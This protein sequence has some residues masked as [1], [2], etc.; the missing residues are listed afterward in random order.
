VQVV[1]GGRL[2]HPA[3]AGGRHCG[4]ARRMATPNGRQAR[5]RT[6]EPKLLLNDNDG[7]KTRR[8]F[9]L[10]IGRRPIRGHSATRP[11][12]RQMPEYIGSRRRG[13][14]FAIAG[15]ARQTH[16]REYAY[17]PRWGMPATPQGRRLLRRRSTTKR[18][19]KWAGP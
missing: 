16:K 5:S 4:A 13:G 7:G 8:P 17:G 6:R 15:A 9:T 3:G 12:D 1:R 11:A 2:R 18:K 19:R 14:G 10:K